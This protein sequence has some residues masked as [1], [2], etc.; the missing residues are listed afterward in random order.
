VKHIAL[1][2]LLLISVAGCKKHCDTYELKFVNKGSSDNL[3]GRFNSSWTVL[4]KAHSDT[5]VIIDSKIDSVYFLKINISETGG[6]KLSDACS[7][8]FDITRY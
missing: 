8:E 1:I 6:Y 3:A 7:Q 2:L 4:V 5:T